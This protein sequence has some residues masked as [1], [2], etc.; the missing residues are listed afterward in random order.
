MLILVSF[1]LIINTSRVELG[2]QFHAI[3]FFQINF[4]LIFAQLDPVYPLLVGLLWYPHCLSLQ[5]PSHILIKHRMMNYWA[6]ML[7]KSA[8][9]VLFEPHK[10]PLYPWDMVCLIDLILLQ[11]HYRRLYHFNKRNRYWL[12]IKWWTTESKSAEVRDFCHT[13]APLDPFYPLVGLFIN[14]LGPILSITFKW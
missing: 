12:R 7:Q 2:S 3:Y 13:W 11:Y 10:G 5:Q 6:E 14:G 1:Q 4:R 8:I 9:S